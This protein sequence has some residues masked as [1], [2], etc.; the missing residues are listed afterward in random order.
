VYR[1]GPV[2]VLTRATAAATSPDTAIDTEALRVAKLEQDRIQSGLAGQVLEPIGMLNRPSLPDPTG[3]ILAAEDL[4]E[5]WS[6]RS[7]DPS[8]SAEQAVR[9]VTSTYTN[10]TTYSAPRSAFLRVALAPDT[11]RAR[12]GFALFIADGIGQNYQY[13]QVPG[14]GDEV[15]YKGTQIMDDGRVTVEYVYRLGPAVVSVA[16][17]SS[18]ASVDELSQ[19]ARDIAGAQQQHA[20]DILPTLAMQSGATSD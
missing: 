18:D 10:E 8:G 9:A 20:L 11:P 1:V 12:K 4:G 2:V 19:Q 16:L 7:V 3:V 6:S 15:A 13:V 14:F 5:G 17:R